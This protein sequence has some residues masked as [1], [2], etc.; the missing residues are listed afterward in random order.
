MNDVD[1][2]I[3]LLRAGQVV[4]LPTETVYGLA[5]DA[6]QAEAVK[7]I[8]EIKKRPQGHPLI[9]HLAELGWLSSYCSGPLD[10]AQKLGTAFWPGPL[11]LILPRREGTVP[12]VVTGGLLTVGVRVPR[13][14]RALEVIAGLGRPVA[15][16]SANRFGGVSPTTRAHVLRDLGD[17]VPL[18]VEGGFCEVGL[19][20]TILDLSRKDAYLLRPGA[21]TRQDL[22]A[23]LQEPV[24]EDDGHGPAAP[25]TLDSH[26]A[27][28][29]QVIL[30]SAEHLWSLAREMAT[31]KRVGVLALPG[32]ETPRD[33]TCEVF[34]VTGDLNAAAHEL[35]A[36]LRQLDEAGCE[37]IL[38]TRPD[39]QGIGIAIV[40]RLN[41]AAAPRDPSTSSTI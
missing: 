21:I 34:E 2:A 10:R 1:A 33:V 36:A 16:P 40:D 23:V 24:Y 15:A 30:V 8:F 3:F 32:N 31:S 20:S 12:D 11:T 17:D 35:Y 29:A 26:Y 18:V 4:G 7:K 14:A 37:V 13:H 41:R 38:S 22:E 6:T 27:P 25:G 39:L 28:R 19:E 9:V 5:A